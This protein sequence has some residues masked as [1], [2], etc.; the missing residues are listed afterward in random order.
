MA[1]THVLYRFYGATG[2]LLYVGITMNPPQRF[3]AHRGSKDWW[4]DVVGITLEHY[5]TRE[6]LANAERRAIQVE[7]PLHNVVR[8]KPKP[9]QQQAVTPES[10][11]GVEDDVFKPSLGELFGGIFGRPT[12]EDPY[13]VHQRERW[14][15]IRACSLCDEAGYLGKSVC[16]HVDRSAGAVAARHRQAQKDKLQVIDGGGV[17]TDG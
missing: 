1:E 16:Y 8:A 15:A 3:R 14:E 13:I 9:E 2:Q 7:R 17:R 10:P 6:D 5:D 12:E 11:P 4:G